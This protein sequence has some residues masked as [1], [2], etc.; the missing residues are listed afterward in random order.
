MADLE[1]FVKKLFLPGAVYTFV[2]PAEN[3]RQCAESRASSPG[4]GCAR[5]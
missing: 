1:A 5:A 3:P 4:A 2:E